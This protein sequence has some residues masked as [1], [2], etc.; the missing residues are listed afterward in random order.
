MAARA[1]FCRE[2]GCQIPRDGRDVLSS[3]YRV[4]GR[5]LKR[6]WIERRFPQDLGWRNRKARRLHLTVKV[7]DVLEDAFGLLINNALQ[8][9]YVG[10]LMLFFPKSPLTSGNPVRLALGVHRS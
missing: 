7:W 8:E 3:P 5:V 10:L 1:G 2:T 9:R 4:A 6:F